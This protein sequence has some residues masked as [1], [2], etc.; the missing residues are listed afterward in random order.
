MLI[1]VPFFRRLLYNTRLY[2]LPDT[3]LS[4]ASK[5]LKPSTKDLYDKDGIYIRFRLLNGN[6]FNLRQ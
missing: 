5:M 3:L 2:S 1:F 6:L 4:F